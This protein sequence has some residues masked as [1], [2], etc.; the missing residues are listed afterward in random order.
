MTLKPWEFYDSACTDVGTDFFYMEDDGHHVSQR[1]KLE[2]KNI[3]ESCTHKNDCAKWG[4][5]NEIFGIWGGL[6]SEERNRHRR[7]MRIRISDGVGSY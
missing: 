6:T 5:S 1:Q 3:C 2:I 4:I 7:R